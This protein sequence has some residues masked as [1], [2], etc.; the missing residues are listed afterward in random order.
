MPNTRTSALILMVLATAATRLLPHPPN[1]TSM[2]AVALFAGAGFADRRLAF[3]VPLAALLLSDLVL[4]LYW[5]W[6]SLMAWQPHMWVQYACF[7]AIVGLGMQLRDRGGFW[8]VARM[9]LL[10]SVFFFVVTNFAEWVF[11]PWYAKNFAGLA[12][13]YVAALPFF[14]NAL[15]GDF[16]FALLLFGGLRL[17]EQRFAA[18]REPVA[19]HAAA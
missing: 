13:C 18:L 10:A 9:T 6:S 17:L 19:A 14:R 16:G 2:T 1:M 11:Q 4:G 12:A 15:I 8:R 7:A 5:N 3:G